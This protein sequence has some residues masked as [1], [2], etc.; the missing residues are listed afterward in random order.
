MSS[1]ITQW[2]QHNSRFWLKFIFLSLAMAVVPSCAL[3][4][5]LSPMQ[6]RQIQTRTFTDASYKTVFRAFKTILQDEGYSIKDQDM[7]GGL[8]V[9]SREQSRSRLFISSKDKEEKDRDYI[10]SEGKE[11]SVNLEPINKKT[12]E[13]RMTIHETERFKYSGDRRRVTY[14]AKYYT[15]IF[16]LTRVEVERRKAKGRK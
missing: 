3:F 1:V 10:V 4:K 13:V 14:Y 15:N 2:C 8:I 11:V 7:E 5:P 9:A 16:N 12:T 6:K